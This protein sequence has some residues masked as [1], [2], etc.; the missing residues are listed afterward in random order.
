MANSWLRLWHD[1]PNDPKWRTIAKVSKHPITSVISVYIHILVIASNA[2][3]RGR[4]NAMCSEDIASALDIDC[5]HVEQIIDAMQGRVLDGD[6]VSGW[7]KRQVAREDGSAERS[8]AW[9]EA[10][11]S[12]DKTQANA[13]ERKQAL[14][15]DKDKDKEDKKQ[16][17]TP[18]GDLFDGIDQQIIADFK[19]LRTKKKAAITKTAIDGIR[20]EATIAGIS[21]ADALTMCCE[22]G[23]TGFKAEWVT[24]PR[25]SPA[26]SKLG[27]AGQ[28][29]AQA[30]QRLR[31][32]MMAA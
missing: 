10:K 28:E 30:A 15:K 21:L 13:T 3:E 16:T 18:S 5:E 1:M 29:T 4:T 23:W 24:K 20:R 9:R 7:D 26:G 8:K 2:T 14:D 11:K 31:E 17:H 19:A 12:E 32:R 6:M 22:R 27:K 25:E